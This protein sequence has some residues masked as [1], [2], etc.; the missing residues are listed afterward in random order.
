MYVNRPLSCIWGSH[1]YNC[2]L[3]SLLFNDFTLDIIKESN[4]ETLSS[5]VFD[6]LVEL[7]TFCEFSLD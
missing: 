7:L 6:G 2:L 5:F 1:K 4:G 3:L